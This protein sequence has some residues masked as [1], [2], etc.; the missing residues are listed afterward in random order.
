MRLDSLKEA[1]KSEGLRENPDHAG[2]RN[3]D[4]TDLIEQVRESN[5]KEA[6]E[7]EVNQLQELLRNLTGERNLNILEVNT[8]EIKWLSKEETEKASYQRRRISEVY[9]IVNQFLDAYKKLKEE[10]DEDSDFKKYYYGN[11]KGSLFET[12]NTTIRI[13]S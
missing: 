6:S 13:K 10:V 5:K 8:R 2:L 9:E 4:S 3:I 1:I 11:P 7:D 12:L